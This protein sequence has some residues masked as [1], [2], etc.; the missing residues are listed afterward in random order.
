MPGAPPQ[1]LCKHLATVRGGVPNLSRSAFP[2]RA[3]ASFFLWESYEQTESHHVSFF[4]CMRFHSVFCFPSQWKSLGTS[5]TCSLGQKTPGN[6]SYTVR[7]SALWP[8]LLTHK[9]IRHM[10]LLWRLLGGALSFSCGACESWMELLPLPHPRERKGQR[11]KR[12]PH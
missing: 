1:S 8:H 9:H 4:L 2:G 11:K 5:V 7:G 10:P 3:P 6:K 12:D